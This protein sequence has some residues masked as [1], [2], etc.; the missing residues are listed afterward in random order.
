MSVLRVLRDERI[1]DRIR[2]AKPGKLCRT[3]TW[4]KSTATWLGHDD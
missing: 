2:D 4:I 3:P 1:G